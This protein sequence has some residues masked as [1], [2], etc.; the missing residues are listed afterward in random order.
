MCLDAKLAERRARPC[1]FQGVAT[2]VPAR[3]VNCAVGMTSP[4]DASSSPTGTPLLF[5]FFVIF[6][7]SI[8]AL[9]Y[10]C[11]SVDNAIDC[12]QICGRYA[13]CWDTHY[14]VEACADRCRRDGEADRDYRRKSDICDACMDDRS[15]A[16]AT[17][18]CASEC[19]G[20]VP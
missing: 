18:A 6:A 3:F 14:N 20:I 2:H 4:T 17:F 12:R 9:L 15:C 10:G 11:D 5:A 8:G 19:A 13:S 7:M 1:V 16:A